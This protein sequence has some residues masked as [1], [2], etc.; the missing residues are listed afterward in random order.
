MLLDDVCKA[1][2]SPRPRSFAGLMEMYE[3]NYIRLRRLCPDLT[4]LDAYSISQVPDALDL[5]LRVLEQCPFTTT[6]GLTYVFFDVQAGVQA[7]PDLRLRVYHDAR[8][9][10]VLGRACRHRR[11]R[12]RVEDLP[13]DTVLECKWKLNR[14]LYKWLSYCL[15]QGHSFAREHRVTPE[16]GYEP[17]LLTSLP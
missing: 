13:G 4:E 12:V 9:V 8:Q 16:P 14:F 3:W 1:C 17:G 11:G 10:E 5:H 2:E 6:L 15:R 7:N